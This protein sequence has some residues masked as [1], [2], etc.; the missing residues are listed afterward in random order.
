MIILGSPGASAS[1]GTLLLGT[2]EDPAT[3]CQLCL[4]LPRPLRFLLL[5]LYRLSSVD[6]TCRTGSSPLL[7]FPKWSQQ[8]AFP[9]VNLTILPRHQLLR[10]LGLECEFLLPRLDA[11]LIFPRMLVHLLS[12]QLWPIDEVICFWNALTLKRGF[13]GTGYIDIA[14]QSCGHRMNRGLHTE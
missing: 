6:P 14:F 8:T 12:G 3:P 5:P 2:Y 1:L 7:V 13:E 11:V 10:S 9:G 4:L